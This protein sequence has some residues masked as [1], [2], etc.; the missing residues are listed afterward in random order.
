M[1]G[2]WQRIIHVAPTVI[3]LIER[4]QTQTKFFGRPFN[5][6]AYVHALWDIS[7]AGLGDFEQGE[8][9]LEKGLSFAH[10]IHDLG[11]VGFIEIPYG[12]LLALK[13]AG[14]RAAT[15]FRNAIKNLEESQTVAFLGVAWAWLG[16]AHW[17]MGEFKMAVELTEKGLR[18]HLDLGMPFYRSLCHFFLSRAHFGEGHVEEA[19]TYVELALQFSL[20]NNEGQAQGLARTWLGRVVAIT[21]PTHIEEA[22]QHILQGINILEVLGI[23]ASSSLGYL[24]ARGGLS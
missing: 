1:S 18:M 10:E 13:G 14:D 2:D 6:Y 9:L 4:S 5:P 3:G 12:S 7:A 22:E 11:T 21:N 16:Y 8:S 15:H 19:R 17:L 24:V 23:R 20:E